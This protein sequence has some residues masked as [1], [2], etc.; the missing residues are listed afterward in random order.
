MVYLRQ[1]PLTDRTDVVLS[2]LRI[3]YESAQTDERE[4]EFG[5][6]SNTHSHCPLS[7]L[8]SRHGLD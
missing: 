8:I 5:L 3:S 7:T 6:C 1:M 4:V 2:P